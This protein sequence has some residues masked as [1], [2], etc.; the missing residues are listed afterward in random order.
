MT[1]LYEAKLATRTLLSGMEDTF[2]R[3]LKKEK[4]MEG[5]RTPE[6]NRLQG[7]LKQLALDMDAMEDLLSRMQG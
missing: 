4:E 7:R 1:S 5:R 6:L 3:L 2:N